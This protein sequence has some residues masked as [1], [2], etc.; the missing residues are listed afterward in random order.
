MPLMGSSRSF[1]FCT[2]MRICMRC[3]KMSALC[4]FIETT[5]SLGAS[6]LNVDAQPESVISS[7][8]ATARS[9]SRMAMRQHVR[10]DQ[11]HALV[12]DQVL[13]CVFGAIEADARA[14]GEHAMLVDDGIADLAVGSDAHVRQD[15]RTL[16]IGTLLDAHA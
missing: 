4:T 16:D 7:A 8:A 12:R 1:G 13:L 10:G 9:A 2:S 15:H 6:S 14:G 11:H 3:E 5:D